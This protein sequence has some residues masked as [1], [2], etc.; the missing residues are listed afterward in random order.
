M[1]GWEILKVFLHSWQRGTNSP[2]HYEDHTTLPTLTLFLFHILPP[3]LNALPCHLQPPTPIT[4]VLSVSL[5]LWL[6]DWSCHIRCAILLN[7]IYTWINMDLYMSSLGT[8]VPEGPW[9]VFY[10]TR[11]HVYWGL[12]HTVVFTGTLIWYHTHKHTQ[13]T[14][15]PVNWQTRII[16]CLH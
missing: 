14:L 13:H 9:C 4:N 7:N 6:N 16:I 12:T 1:G 15:G 3:P 2:L 10:A 8:I 11:C 5:F